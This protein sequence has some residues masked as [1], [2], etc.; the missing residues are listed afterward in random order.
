MVVRLTMKTTAE[1][2]SGRTVGGEGG[3]GRTEKDA[4]IKYV[5]VKADGEGLAPPPHLFRRGIRRQIRRRT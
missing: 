1:P 3:R 2:A 4:D 5:D